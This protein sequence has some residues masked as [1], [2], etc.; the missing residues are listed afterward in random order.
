MKQKYIMIILL[1]FA[2]ALNTLYSQKQGSKFSIARIKYSGGGD[3]YNDPSSE[4]NLLEY[5]DKQTN[6]PVEPRYVYVDLAS[7][8]L[9][10]YP[11]IYITGHGNLKFSNTEIQKLRS[12]LQNGGFL[13][14][15]DDYGL[16]EYI[17]GEMSRVFP[18]QKFVELPFS[19]GIYSAH[20]DFPNG[21]PKVHEHDKGS[22]QGFGLF[23]DGRLCVYYTYE[24]NLGDGWADERVHQNPQKKREDALKMG[25]N[26][27]VW[28]LSN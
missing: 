5:I 17:R 27:I 4:V 24:S 13:Y 21:L 18:N 11:V 12:Y 10:L 1:I 25:T 20:F 2:F 23:H 28:A 16:D 14:I 8:N 6:I 3:W 19:H 22:P 9:F 7:D 26:I 15:D